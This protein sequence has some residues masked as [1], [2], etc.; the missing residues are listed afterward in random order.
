MVLEG[1]RALELEGTLGEVTSLLS[2]LEQG[3]Y[4]QDISG[5]P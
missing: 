3:I 4:H 5:G 1:V 2:H